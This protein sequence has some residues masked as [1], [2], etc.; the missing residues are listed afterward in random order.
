[1]RR[2][3]WLLS[4]V[5]LLPMLA[6]AAGG[7]WGAGGGSVAID[8]TARAAAATAMTLAQG[9][10]QQTRNLSDVA[11][12]TVALNNLGGIPA[13]LIGAA[14]GVAGLGSNKLLTPSQIPFGTATGTVADG[15]SLAAAVAMAAAAIPSSKIGA[16][17]GI[18]SLNA[19]KL[20]TPSQ[21]PFG[22]TSGTV[23]DGGALAAAAA[24]A[25]A[26]IPAS[27]IGA[28]SGVA[29]LGSNKLLTSSEIPFGTAAGT[30]ADGGAL[31]AAAATANAAIPVSLIGA[32]SGVAGLGSNKLI[33]GAQLPFGTTSGTVA[34]GGTLA[35]TTATATAAVPGTR[36]GVA[37]GVATLDANK[38]V[39]TSQLPFGTT[40]GTVADGGVLA[41]TMTTANAALPSSKAGAASGVATLDANK[42]LLP[43]QIPFGTATGT[44]AD[45]GAVT[46]AANIA[47]A[48]LPSTKLGVASGAAQLDANKLVPYAQL[49]FGTTT[50]T[51]GD[52]GVLATASSR[53]A[54]A[55]Q[56]SAIGSTIAAYNDPRIT[57]AAPASGAVLTNSQLAADPA[58]GDS[59]KNVADTEWVASLVSKS[60]GTATTVGSGTDLSQGNITASGASSAQTAAAIAS[61]AVGAMPSSEIGAASGVA[62]LDGSKHVPS[63]QIPFGT[64]TGL[65]ADGGQAAATMLVA[66]GAI[67]GGSA[68]APGG[69]LDYTVLRA[70]GDTLGISAAAWAGEVCDIKAHGANGTT[71]GD[72]MGVNFCFAYA[73]A[74]FGSHVFVPVGV[75]PLLATAAN[76]F[77]I[78]NFTTFEGADK[79][80]SQFT[81]NDTNSGNVPSGQTCAQAQSSNPSGTV[82]NYNLFAADNS[83]LSTGRSRDIIVRSLHFTGTWGNSDSTA[84]FAPSSTGS[85]QILSLYAVDGLTVEGNIFDYSRGFGPYI[86]YSSDIKVRDNDLRYLEYDAIPVWASSNVSIT[87]NHIAHT[88]DDCI[89]VHDNQYGGVWIARRDIDIE[90]NTCLDTQAINALGGRYLVIAY[91]H[92]I[93]PKGAAIDVGTANVGY[94]QGNSSAVGVVIAYNQI[95][96]LVARGIVDSYNQGDTYIIIS[97]ISAA[98][99]PYTLIPGQ[100][101][102]AGASTGQDPAPEFFALALATTTA[103]GESHAY[104]VT[105]NTMAS[106]L[107]SFNGSNKD[108]NGNVRFP[109]W[110]SF[111]QGPFVSATGEQNPSATA[112]NAFETAVGVKISG[113][114]RDVAI[115]DNSFAG[116]GTAVQWNTGIYNGFHVRRNTVFNLQ[117]RAWDIENAG[118]NNIDFEDNDIDMDPYVLNVCRGSNGNWQGNTCAD[119]LY[120]AAGSGPGIVYLRNKTADAGADLLGV[121]PSNPVSGDYFADNLDY[122]DFEST[123][124]S[125]YGAVGPNIDSFFNAGI[126]YVHNQGF[127]IIERYGDPTKANYGQIFSAPVEAAAVMPTTGF[128]TPGD[129]VRNSSPL[130]ATSTLPTIAGWKRI[131]LGS[132]DLPGF[133]WA[134]DYLGGTP[135]VARLMQATSL[136][137]ADSSTSATIAFANPVQAADTVLVVMAGGSANAAAAMPASCTLLAGS[138]L[139]GY[140]AA[141]NQAY[142]AWACPSGMAYT[143][144][145]LKDGA[146][147]QGMEVA[148][149]QAALITAAPISQSST[150][151]T[152]PAIGVPGDL[153]LGVVE[154]DG[155]GTTVTTSPAT[156]PITNYPAGSDSYHY[157]F[158][159]SLP[160][161]VAGASFTATTGTSVNSPTYV[162][163]DVQSKPGIN[164]QSGAYTFTQADCD[165]WVRDLGATAAHTYTVPYGLT[166]KCRIDIYQE[167]ANAITV[168]A[169]AGVTL[170]SLNG[171]ATTAG[172]GD[173][174]VVDVLDPATVSVHQ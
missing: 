17:S 172:A 140:S 44:V 95:T 52:G 15:G 28:A 111:G 38:L 40:G 83:Q 69:Y 39:P 27:L 125:T 37:N 155:Q 136:R 88:N 159:Y 19:N 98:K 167:T 75:Y 139:A 73:R 91:N 124:L 8:T 3:A 5:A 110:T 150:T 16:A 53:A 11:N 103:V 87:D 25:N 6:K 57:G 14:S 54:S 20:L 41:A 100:V 85:G 174:R 12:V 93:T 131:T 152:V 34:D 154:W 118:L 65:V 96:D 153:R 116:I 18:A 76:T 106:Y 31:A 144:N 35:T 130:V 123:P 90:H 23:A 64:G 151:L 148:N 80:G 70:L 101:G 21:I 166:P 10:V 165:T 13:G 84:S 43:A 59:S 56:P 146:L 126:R 129:Y 77:L 22:L 49:P 74:H 108:S 42:L 71:A 9:S 122:D 120:I 137:N 92:I 72:A 67:Q 79:N 132:R 134:A 173:H 113:V 156:I 115:D 55:L 143:V 170:R 97:G 94:G 78:P 1:M 47:N 109:S 142:E 99:G 50:N 46:T 66:Q 2:A 61:L 63:A 162:Q 161:G 89:S 127:R 163:I 138:A 169:A 26:S 32:A 58:T 51:V 149:Y 107:P 157:G 171:A 128:W 168:N 135:P 141:T 24:M 145:G 105:H 112:G 102:Y 30:V 82:C 114:M 68:S 119:A 104:S 4:T 7:G 160:A 121:D 117:T 86:N 29:G 147:I 45:G 133:D 158:V 62:Q 81:W 60:V 33:P 164:L 36:L 48:A